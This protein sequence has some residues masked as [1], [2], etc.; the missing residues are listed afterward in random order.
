MTDTRTL[1]SPL[2]ETHW[3]EGELGADDLR[4]IDCSVQIQPNPEGGYGFVSARP[5]FEAGHIPGSLFIDLPTELSDP[6][7]ATD[8]M[9]PPIDRFAATMAGLGIGEGT[10]VV[11]YDRSNH[12]WAARVWWMLRTAGFDDAAVLNGGWQ[13]WVAEDH[14]ASTESVRY[15]ETRFTPRP[16]PHLMASKEDVLASLDDPATRRIYALPPAVYSGEVQL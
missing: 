9:M 2:V 13:K 7:A 5:A 6:E 15:P 16:R 1:P 11:L 10:R 4:I 12:A 3:L 14:P 8:L